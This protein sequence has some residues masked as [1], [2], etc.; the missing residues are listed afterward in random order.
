MIGNH[1]VD[2]VA[3]LQINHNIFVDLTSEF[4]KDKQFLDK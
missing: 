4:R 3:V 2:T 1:M